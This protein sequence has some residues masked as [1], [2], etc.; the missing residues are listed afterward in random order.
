MDLLSP[1]LGIMNLMFRGTKT[2]CP[3]ITSSIHET[4]ATADLFF[5][6]FLSCGIMQ[7][8]DIVKNYAFSALAWFL[9]VQ[10][11]NYKT[12]F[13]NIVQSLYCMEDICGGSWSSLCG[14][15]REMQNT[16]KM[17]R[18]GNGEKDVDKDIYRRFVILFAF[19]ERRKTKVWVKRTHTI[20][21]KSL[22]S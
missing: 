5:S 3:V 4:I 8:Q 18:K 7:K 15:I 21:F 14:K 16:T 12:P 10:P 2:F 20:S 1:F 13:W 17:K 19:S 11:S 22:N 6:F 9:T